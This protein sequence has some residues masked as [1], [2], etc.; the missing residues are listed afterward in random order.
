MGN[1]LPNRFIRHDPSKRTVY[2]NAIGSLAS[3]LGERDAFVLFPEGHDFT[4]PLRL[5]AIA[6]L[7]KR[8]FHR[9]ADQA[10]RMR[11]VLP[12]KLG[13][14]TTAIGAAPNADVVF[15]AHSVLEDVGSF[16]D[17]WSRIPLDRPIRG[18]YWRVA[19]GDV[20]RDQAELAQWVFG[21]WARIDGWI[22]SRTPR[23]ELHADR[24]PPWPKGGSEPP[25][26]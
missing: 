5:R 3:E 13:G 9:E 6:H 25:F 26:P 10:E 19:A 21:W 18:H 8:G 11:Y 22:E 23:L 20:P 17:L 12:P 15:V 16:R 14:V 2:L 24:S 7:R 1:R 4:K